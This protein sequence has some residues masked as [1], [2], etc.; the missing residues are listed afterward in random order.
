M[1]LNA[2]ASEMS[3]APSSGV[4]RASRHQKGEPM[5]DTTITDQ[6]MTIEQEVALHRKLT[7]LRDADRTRF[8]LIAR[9]DVRSLNDA[10]TKARG[11]EIPFPVSGDAIAW[12]RS[13]DAA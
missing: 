10:A 11:R 12:S 2:L 3:E 6:P 1:R 13:K 8:V 7:R 5:S 4:L 9:E